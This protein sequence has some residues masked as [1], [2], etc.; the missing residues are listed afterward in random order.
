[1]NLLH[2]FVTT[3]HERPQRFV[4]ILTLRRPSL[5]QLELLLRCLLHH[6]QNKP[7]DFCS[8]SWRANH[9]AVCTLQRSRTTRPG[10]SSQ[11]GNSTK[12]F[13]HTYDFVTTACDPPYRCEHEHSFLFRFWAPKLKWGNVTPHITSRTASDCQS[14]PLLHFYTRQSSSSPLTVYSNIFIS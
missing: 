12:C 5:L 13:C 4:M 2:D 6:G 9:L 14:I 7:R 1:M 10:S 3:S 11:P 8:E